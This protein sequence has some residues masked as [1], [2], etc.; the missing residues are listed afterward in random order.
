M[1]NTPFERCVLFDV[2]FNHLCYH[3][4]ILYW[5]HIK[6]LIFIERVRLLM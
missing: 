3:M 4:F 6:M 1:T 2:I 5:H